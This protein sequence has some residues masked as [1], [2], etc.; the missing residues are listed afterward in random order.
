VGFGAGAL[1]GI[2]AYSVMRSMSS[3]YRS[4]P[5]YYEPGYGS[6]FYDFIPKKSSRIADLSREKIHEVIIISLFI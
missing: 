1:G 3:S 6:K 5:N 2:A 4:R